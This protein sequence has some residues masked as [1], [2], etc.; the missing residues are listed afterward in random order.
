MEILFIRHAIAE[1]REVFHSPHPK[2]DA[3]RPLTEQGEKKFRKAAQ[4]LHKIF[5][6]PH[7]IVS[8]PYKRALQTAQI[9]ANLYNNMEISQTELLTPEKKPDLFINWIETQEKFYE[10]IVVV[11]HEPHLSHLISFALTG[12]AGAFINVKK[13]SAILLNYENKRYMLQ[14]A[15]KPNQLRLLAEC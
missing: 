4:G 13:G 9:F 11:G 15:L 8:S 10:R 6:A 14:W 7:L 3:L 2:S 1:E 5:G 12:N